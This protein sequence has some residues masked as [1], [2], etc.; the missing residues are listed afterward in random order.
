MFENIKLNIYKNH[1]V[2]FG[3]DYFCKS[4]YCGLQTYL[5][6]GDEQNYSFIKF[7]KLIEVYDVGK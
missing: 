6:V 2:G 5:I 7:K 1:I 4:P 3:Y